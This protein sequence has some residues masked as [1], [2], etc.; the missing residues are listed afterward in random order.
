MCIIHFLSKHVNPSIHILIHPQGSIAD[1]AN[2]SMDEA[3]PCN[4]QQRPKVSFEDEHP[5]TLM[6]DNFINEAKDF[7]SRTFEPSDTESIEKEEPFMKTENGC[8]VIRDQNKVHYIKI[9]DTKLN[10]EDSSLSE[11]DKKSSAS[12]L[13]PGQSMSFES[14]QDNG[15]NEL[16]STYKPRTN[17]NETIVLVDVDYSMYAL[18]TEDTD[19]SNNPYKSDSLLGSALYSSD[20][21][22]AEES[23]VIDDSSLNNTISCDDHEHELT[24]EDETAMSF[25]D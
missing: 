24:D 15:Q 22:G 18:R 12:Q 14:Q 8:T 4:Q 10:E 19:S 7:F 17:E 23:S 6:K 9:L 3:T 16:K 13:L 25:C 5:L 1:I 21:T 20:L 11:E 2:K